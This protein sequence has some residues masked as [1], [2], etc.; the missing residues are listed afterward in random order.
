M[1]KILQLCFLAFVL[2]AMVAPN[3]ALMSFSKSKS[4]VKHPHNVARPVHYAPVYVHRPIYYK[5]VYR[6]KKFGHY[7]KKKFHG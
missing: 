4:F 7:K 6:K 1:A 3:E 2:V 5:P